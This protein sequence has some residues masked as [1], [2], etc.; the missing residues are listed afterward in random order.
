MA[1]LVTLDTVKAYLKIGNDEHDSVLERLID[2]AS[3]TIERFCDQP[4]VKADGNEQH[5]FDGD[6]LSSILML[7]FL[8]V[9][10]VTGVTYLTT[11]GSSATTVD[12]ATYGLRLRG[13][14]AYLHS[15]E[16]FRS[17][18]RYTVTLTVGFDAV[19][20]DVEQVALEMVADMA[21]KSNVAG[22]GENRL[23]LSSKSSGGSTASSASFR[24]MRE[25]WADRLTPYRRPAL[26]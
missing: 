3:S 15:T 21:R 10:A 4:I 12:A 19:P 6:D 2:V 7:P 22:I 9:R 14:L 8:Q 23:G 5:E 25:E 24:D 13:G 17:S 11:V 20:P 18:R 26:L 16:T 1:D